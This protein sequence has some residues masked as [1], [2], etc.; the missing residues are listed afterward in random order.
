MP[1]SAAVPDTGA[2]NGA[3]AEV[4]TPPPAGRPALLH[5]LGETRAVW[6]RRHQVREA[7]VPAHLPTREWL[8]RAA[9]T[10]LALTALATIALAAFGLLAVG[11]AA[12]LALPVVAACAMVIG[13]WMGAEAARERRS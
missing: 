2:A 13:F 9:F 7:V 11:E 1:E 8:V 5:A 6:E 3:G 12:A 4:Q 10:L